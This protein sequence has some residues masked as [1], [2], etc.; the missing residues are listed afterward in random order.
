MHDFFLE[1]RP[2]C[3]FFSSV[4]DTNS[5]A[6][7]AAANG[8]CPTR[9]INDDI[10]NNGFVDFSAVAGIG[11]DRALGLIAAAATYPAP[12]ITID[13]GTATTINAMGKDSACVGGAILPGILTQI[14]SLARG[15]A[16]LPQIHPNMPVSAAGRNTESAIASGTVL[17]TCHAISGI[18]KSIIAEEFGGQSARIAVTGGFGE[19][20]SRGLLRLGIANA[21]HPD[22]VLR[23]IEALCRN[24]Q[25]PHS[26]EG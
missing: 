19:M 16:Q 18:A 10:P 20:V 13:C 14:R 4:N 23:G 22:L 15:T 2:D 6:L 8:I 12:I 21:F 7:I 25:N 3:V 24:R 26:S 9:S 17:G 1:N 11:A 5:Q